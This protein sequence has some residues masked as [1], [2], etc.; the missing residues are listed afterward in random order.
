MSDGGRAGRAEAAQYDNGVTASGCRRACGGDAGEAVHDGPA[1]AD[2][3]VL[4]V[5]TARRALYERRETAAPVRIR[6][7]RHEGIVVA[8]TR[9]FPGLAG[10]AATWELTLADGR[11]LTAPAALPDLRPG[12]TAAVPLPFTLPRDGGEAWLA[13]RVVTA[14][15]EPPA[16]HG[17]EVCAPRVRLWAA[18]PA[19]AVPAPV[20]M[21]DDGLP[22]HPVPTAARALAL[23]WAPSDAPGRASRGNGTTVPE[24]NVPPGAQRR[25]RSLR[26]L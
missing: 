14:E 1:A 3:V 2:E 19:A 21:D 7:H 11:T 6:C 17:T 20:E 24:D 4:P 18:A 16:P 5:G 25:S 22:V 15:D 9:R 12:E 13:L 26:L 10:L 23:G 8:N